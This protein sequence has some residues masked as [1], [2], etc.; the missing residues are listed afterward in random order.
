MIK[1]KNYADKGVSTVVGILILLIVIIGIL[2]PLS[3]T[4][5]SRPTTQQQQIEV[6]LPYQNMAQQQLVDFEDIIPVPDS[7]PMPPVSF[8]YLGNNSVVF[9]LNDNNT[10][11]IPLI[12][13]Y[14]EVFN[15]T[16]WVTLYLEKQGDSYIAIPTN[17]LTE[18][19]GVTII[20]NNANVNYSYSPAIL[21]NL[22][23]SVKPYNNQAQYI[24]AITQYG[25]IITAITFKI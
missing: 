13:K 5:L 25:N 9:V 21:I 17:Q 2:I 7:N 1:R 15:G 10:P 18:T 19:N 8:I 22:P 14:L 3:S 12:I 20:P 24:K 4:L 6:A 23:P 11:P 16:Q